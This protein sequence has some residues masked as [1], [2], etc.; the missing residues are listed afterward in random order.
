M[1]SHNHVLKANTGAG[2]TPVANT[3]LGSVFNDTAV[4]GNAGD[5]EAHPNVQ[6]TAIVNSIIKT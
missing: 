3:T 4:I 5:G 6:P 2:G 1:P